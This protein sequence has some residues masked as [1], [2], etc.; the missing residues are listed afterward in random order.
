MT[1][2][3]EYTTCTIYSH[4][5]TIYNYYSTGHSSMA[6]L[7]T[8]HYSPSAIPGD[9][10]SS[11]LRIIFTS[12][13]AR[14]ICCFLASNVSITCCE[15]MSRRREREGRGPKETRGERSR[16]REGKERR[17]KTTSG[18]GG[19]GKR[20]GKLASVKVLFEFD[21]QNFFFFLKKLRHWCQLKTKRITFVFSFR[22][23]ITFLIFI[24]ISHSHFPLS[25][26]HSIP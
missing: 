8:H 1:L 15:R 9:L 3:E 10:I 12:C 22:F 25:S 2:D 19:K 23:P 21:P 20:F 6:L 14:L 17:E 4:Y 7:Y 26:S 5:N 24:P 16:E 18:E 13:V 11:I